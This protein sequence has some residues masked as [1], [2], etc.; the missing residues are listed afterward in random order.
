[1]VTVADDRPAEQP[2]NWVSAGT[3]SPLDRPCRYSSGST[4]AMRGK[5]RHH[6]GKIAEENRHRCPVCSSMRLSFTRGIL[7]STAPA[8]VITVRGST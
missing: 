5:R 8:L 4:S 2:R 6:G 3:K 1:M 7:T